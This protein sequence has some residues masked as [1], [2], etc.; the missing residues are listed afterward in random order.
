MGRGGYAKSM[1]I[2]KELNEVDLT[3]PEGPLWITTGDKIPEN[4]IVKTTR[5]G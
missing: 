5:I 1:Q 3:D 4:K 2:T